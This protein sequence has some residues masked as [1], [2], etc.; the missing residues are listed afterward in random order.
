[1]NKIEYLNSKALLSDKNNVIL[2][3]EKKVF[4]CNKIF[5]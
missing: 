4:I 5:A 3:K 2:N 1:M